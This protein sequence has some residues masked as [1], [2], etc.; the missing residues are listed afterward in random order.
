MSNKKK[1]ET[2]QV[3]EGFMARAGFVLADWSE[4]WFPDAYIF[5]IIAVVIV[6]LAAL[7]MGRTPIQIGVDFGSHFW[8]LVPFAMQMAFVV[9]SG[10]VVATSKPVNRLIVKLSAIPKTPKTAV[11]FVAFFAMVASLLSWGFSL[12]F[13]GILIREVSKRVKGVDYRAIG[14]AGYL[15]LGS[16]WALGLSSAPALLMTTKSSIPPSLYK[17]SG[18]IP[19]TETIFTW[20][21]LV[22]IIV[23][24]VMS[25]TICYYSTPNADKAKTAEMA[26]INYGEGED[27]K[28]RTKA[29]KPGEW[30]EYSPILTLVIVSIGIVY[31]F[32]IINTKGPIAALDLNTY[33][34]I[35]LMLGMLLHWT[36]R[37]FLNAAAKAIPATGGVLIQFPIYAGIFGVL[38]GSG[39]TELLM[40]FFLSISTQN[41]FP[42]IVGIYSAILGLF[43]PSGGGKF[44]VEAPYLLEAA[45]HLHVGLGWV[46]QV[47]NAA[48]ALPNFINPFWMLPLMGIMGVKA[49]D[50]AGFSILQLV[51]HLPVVIFMVWILA[52]TVPYIPA[53]F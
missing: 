39:L 24:I 9:I 20:Q 49:R 25:V 2:G 22:M 35:F 17:I 36:P 16:I 6:G 38:M 52:K 21:N 8:D 34:F 53:I 50:L 48:E 15:G 30:L 11:A 33:N 42:A 47:Y 19:L 40:K 1:S 31:V 7:F 43:L 32:N 3:K 27:T 45:K 10:Y 44:V 26:G 18:R 28:E 13:S 37:S 12:I 41:T 51:F 23:L 5:A 4:K 14:A 46:I 29:E